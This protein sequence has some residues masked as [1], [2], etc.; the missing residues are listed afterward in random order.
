MKA[1]IALQS[2]FMQWTAIAIVHHSMLMQTFFLDMNQCNEHHLL[3]TNAHENDNIRHHSQQHSAL[4]QEAPQILLPTG[5]LSP[6]PAWNRQLFPQFLHLTP[7]H[8]YKVLSSH[9]NEGVTHLF[10]W[11]TNLLWSM[12]SSCH[13][14]Y[15]MLAPYAEEPCGPGFTLVKLTHFIWSSHYWEAQL[16][17]RLSC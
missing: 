17:S 2:C 9:C 1:H 12:T 5:V 14:S 3:G 15:C 8:L 7:K 4:T 13:G 11:L 6:P 10:W 16:F